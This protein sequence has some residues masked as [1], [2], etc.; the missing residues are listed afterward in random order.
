MLLAQHHIELGHAIGEIKLAGDSVEGIVFSIT[1]I[2]PV[3][4]QAI[5]TLNIVN[6]V[7]HQVVDTG[8]FK[9]GRETVGGGHFKQGL[10]LQTAIISIAKANVVVARQQVIGPVGQRTIEAQTRQGALDGLG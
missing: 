9:V 5:G 3:G 1:V 6:R 7:V 2:H 10:H 4:I 8:E